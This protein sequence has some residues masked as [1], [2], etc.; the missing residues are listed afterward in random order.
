MGGDDFGRYPGRKVGANAKTRELSISL[1][2]TNLPVFVFIGMKESSEVV[3]QVF[4]AMKEALEREK[5]VKIAGLENFMLHE[6]GPRKGRNP[7]RGEGI[8]IRGRRVVTFKPSNVFRKAMS[9]AEA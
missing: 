8:I 3:E 7:Q 1:L 6:K 5:K 9:R 2:G 4:E